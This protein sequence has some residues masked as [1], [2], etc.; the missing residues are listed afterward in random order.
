M[1]PLNP[2][3]KSAYILTIANQKGG[4]GKTTSVM[5]LGVALAKKGKRVLLIDADPQANLTSYLG[6]TPGVGEWEDLLSL[7]QLL[8]SKK[9]VASVGISA[10]ITGTQSGVDLIAADRALTGVEYYLFSRSDRELILKRAIRGISEVYDLILIDTPPSL[11]TLTL[12]AL[13]ASDGVLVPVQ[14][15][16]FSVEGIVKIRESIEE[17]RARWN[18]SLQIVGILPTQVNTR[19]RLSEEVLAAI[20]KEM[21]ALLFQSIIHENASVTESSGHGRSVLDYDRMSKGA[22]DYLAAADELLKRI[23]MEGSTIPSGLPVDASE[24]SQQMKENH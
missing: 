9:P 24:V 18:E 12:N 5:N 11:N 4:V 13:C 15:E 23:G 22:Q 8:L 2:K 14:P 6:V 16:F 17:I 21:P 3:E 7:D 20:Q 1:T 19:R 10:Y